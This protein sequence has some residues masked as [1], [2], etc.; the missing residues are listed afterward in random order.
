[1]KGLARLVRLHYTVPFAL[2]YTLILFYALGGRM[3]GE[4][5][6]AGL[7]TLALA[8]VIAAGYA[9]NDVFDVEVDRVNA[10]Q[11]PLV[12]GQVQPAAAARFGVALLAAGLG[13]G[14]LCRWQFLVTLAAVAAALV[15]Y[16]RTSKRLGAAKQL[17]VAALMVSLYPLAFAQAGGA[18]GPRAASLAVFPVWLFLTAFGYEVLKDLRDAAGD[19][20]PGVGPTPLQRN[21][22][23]WRRIA[24]LAIVGAVPVAL[25]PLGQGCHGV[26]LGVAAV[27]L[28]AGVASAFLDV[29]RAI[30]ATYAD[31]FLV[32]LAA[33]ADVVVHGM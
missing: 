1:M 31:V 25:L 7:S 11:R 8:L 10:P 4:W 26:Y 23:R 32:A 20:A 16:D 22:E 5:L 12:A 3:A 18:S 6:G 13:L 14:A 27:G 15:A 2:G 9:L 33:T 24:S 30:V 28:A 19:R 29:R 17:A 21:P